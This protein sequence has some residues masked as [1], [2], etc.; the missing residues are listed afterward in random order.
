MEV[1]TKEFQK[2]GYFPS[3][4]FSKDPRILD[5]WK[6]IESEFSSCKNGSK[7]EERNLGSFGNFTIL[8]LNNGIS[9]VMFKAPFGNVEKVQE[10]EKSVIDKYLEEIMKDIGKKYKGLKK[11]DS[12]YGDLD[13]FSISG[14]D[15]FGGIKKDGKSNFIIA[16]FVLH[17]DYFLDVYVYSEFGL[18]ILSAFCK[19]A[20]LLF[21]P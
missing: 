18:V 8:R 19:K 17:E 10:L 15:C 13:F 12:F 3:G 16:Q 20:G 9:G 5:L 14:A 21:E 2:E 11:E 1:K 7:K 4:V 6:K